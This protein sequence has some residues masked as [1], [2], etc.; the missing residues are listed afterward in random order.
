MSY[1]TKEDFFFDRDGEGKLLPVD[2][3]LESVPS[4]PMVKVI[5]MNKGQLAEMGKKLKNMESDSET[6]IDIIIKYCVEPK[7]TEDD[8]QSLLSSGKAA[9]VSSIVLG[10]IS[11]STGVDQKTLIE[12]GK[13]TVINNQ[14][15]DFH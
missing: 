7:F 12:E 6:D 8:R 15:Q 13:K 1:L 5:P 3:I 9:I 4:K 11:I 10:I 14:L 2:I